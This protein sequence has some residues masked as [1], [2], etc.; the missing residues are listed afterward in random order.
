MW[1]VCAGGRYGEPSA[2]QERSSPD[3]APVAARKRS[4]GGGT[5]SKATGPD[6]WEKR[7]QDLADFVNKNGFRPR[8]TAELDTERHLHYW[9]GQQQRKLG[10]GE[11][12]REQAEK[13]SAVLEATKG[14]KADTVRK[15]AV[16]GG[17]SS[18]RRSAAAAVQAA[19]DD[20]AGGDEGEGGDDAAVAGEQQDAFEDE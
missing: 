18:S 20:D 10:K 9:M 4:T 12:P 8:R 11:L 13:L 14:K 7:F 5:G 15:T 6:A 1:Y 17:G 2:A 3:G 19:A 16:G